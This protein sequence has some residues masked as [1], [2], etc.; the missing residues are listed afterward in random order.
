MP[1]R[2]ALFLVTNCLGFGSFCKMEHTTWW[3]PMKSLSFELE[4]VLLNKVSFVLPHLFSLVDHQSLRKQPCSWSSP[5]R[6]LGTTT[7]E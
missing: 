1:V 6:A 4:K 2:R 7:K 5:P 3:I